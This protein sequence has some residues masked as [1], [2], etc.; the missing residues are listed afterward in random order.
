MK[1]VK[2]YL[3]R[4]RLV[5][6]IIIAVIGIDQAIK[7]AVKTQMYMRESI[8]VTDWFYIFFTENPGMAFGWELFDKI[9]LTS[10]RLIL[11]VGIGY[12]LFRMIR[13]KAPYG[14]VSCLALVWAG[15]MGNVVDCV[16]YGQIFNAPP[17]PEVARFVA[18]GT[19]YAPLML[20]RVVDMF[21]FPL[22]AFDWPG[23]VPFVG[24]EHFIF[25]SPVFNFA[26]AAISC[27][28][29]ALL[30]FYRKRLAWSEIK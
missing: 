3:T 9:F 25:F 6:L 24:G 2:E 10:F 26:D 13:A 19:G 27:G 14:Y 21:Y 7:V 18:F 4:G 28:V 20:G 12:Y 30:L 17:A 8:R 16:F 1:K 15:A 5:L 11:A 22:F 29:V 23:W